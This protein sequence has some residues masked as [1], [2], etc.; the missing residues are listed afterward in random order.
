MGALLDIGRPSTISFQTLHYLSKHYI[1]AHWEAPDKHF[2]LRHHNTD[3]RC[4]AKLD[5]SIN[6]R[7]G[8]GY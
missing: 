3:D 1:E 5:G 6:E 4:A 2:L 7:D 8:A